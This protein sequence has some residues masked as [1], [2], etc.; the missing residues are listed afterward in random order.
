MCNIHNVVTL[1]CIWNSVF[2]E[3]LYSSFYTRMYYIRNWKKYSFYVDNTID[4]IQGFFF[5]GH[6]NKCESNEA[7]EVSSKGKN[8]WGLS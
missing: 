3:N 6:F 4:Q 1:V 8:K 2:S 5:R 7:K